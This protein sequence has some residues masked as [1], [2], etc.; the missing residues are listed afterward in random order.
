MTIRRVGQLDNPARMGG[1]RSVAVYAT[2]SGSLFTLHDGRRRKISNATR[3][4]T[5]TG[6]SMKGERP[7][8]VV[9]S[10]AERDTSE[11]D[12]LAIAIENSL[13]D[14]QNL[15]QESTS[16]TTSPNCVICMENTANVMVRPCNHVC[17]CVL[18]SQRMTRQPCPIC[19][20]SNVTIER[21][22]F[23]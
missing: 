2:P 11:S 1:A 6:T 12:Q 14:Q 4:H 17:M 5:L 7:L 10:V 21:I 15:R 22:Y 19:R 13:R 18:C 16:A 20:L 8:I 9:A 3:W 23:S